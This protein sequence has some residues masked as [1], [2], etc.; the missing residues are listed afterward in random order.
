MPFCRRFG[1]YKKTRSCVLHWCQV[2]RQFLLCCDLRHNVQCAC[3]IF[4]LLVPPMLEHTFYSVW[5]AFWRENA[6]IL[7]QMWTV[8]LQQRLNDEKLD[9][10]RRSWEWHWLPRDLW[11]FRKHF[12]VKRFGAWR[13]TLLPL[14]ITLPNTKQDSAARRSLEF[15]DLSLKQRAVNG[16][17][18]SM[19][20]LCWSRTTRFRREF[21]S[22]VK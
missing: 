8:S 7:H 5:A 19:W 16:P 10:Q 1:S 17:Q 22:W 21:T 14:G 12:A 2:Q 3:C 9:Y 13:S 11:D 4:L 20:C 18:S 6:D 15:F